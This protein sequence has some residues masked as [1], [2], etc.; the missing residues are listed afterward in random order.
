MPAHGVYPYSGALWETLT[1]NFYM[2]TDRCLLAE[3]LLYDL[4]KIKF[5]LDKGMNPFICRER[6][7]RW[8]ASI[9][10]SV[11]AVDTPDWD[12][13]IG[14]DD[15]PYCM[16]DQFVDGSY[17]D[18]WELIYSENVDPFAGISQLNLNNLDVDRFIDS[19]LSSNPEPKFLAIAYPSLG[20]VY[21]IESPSVERRGYC[22]WKNHQGV[23]PLEDIADGEEPGP[24]DTYVLDERT[25]DE[26]KS[27]ELS[28]DQQADVGFNP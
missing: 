23:H 12:T 9:R 26:W 14:L 1:E 25:Y 28:Y 16:L 11:G 4:N 21:V 6:Y 7:R 17:G 20:A 24:F 10:D 2:I 3:L 13:A 27:L 22:G 8:Q 5:D 15:W 18:D 19:V